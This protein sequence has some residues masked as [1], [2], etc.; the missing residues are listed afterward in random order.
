MPY[1]SHLIVRRL[2]WQAFEKNNTPLS[3]TNKRNLTSARSGLKTRIAKHNKQAI[4]LLGP[5]PDD[6][7]QPENDILFGAGVILGDMTKQREWETGSSRASRDRSTRQ[8]EF[9]GI[10]L[11]SSRLQP[12]GSLLS[13]DVLSRAGAYEIT[14]RSAWLAHLLHEI[15]LSLVVQVEIFRRTIKRT[16]GTARLGQREKVQVTANMKEQY[17]S[18]RLYAQQYNVFRGRMFMIQPAP[19][20]AGHPEYQDSSRL[21]RRMYKELVAADIRCDTTAYDAQGMGTFKLPWFWKLNARDETISD[22]SFI[23]DC[24]RIQYFLALYIPVSQTMFSVFRIRWI[25]AR[26]G[27]DRCDEEMAI[28]RVEMGLIYRGYR[29]LSNVWAA[30]A[31]LMDNLGDKEA[32]AALAREQEEIW[33]EYAKRARHE[34]N[35][36]VPNV[37]P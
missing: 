32:H 10:D 28:L 2:S 24:K 11:P 14:L 22:E 4:E 13:T 18:V 30:R 33:E 19:G 36:L 7:T 34:F 3:A 37:L 20:R 9:Y 8:P 26:A 6:P 1:S 31:D 5:R 23:Q 25:N 17:Q 15:C 21:Q 12:I 29:N 16:P 27:V 35:A